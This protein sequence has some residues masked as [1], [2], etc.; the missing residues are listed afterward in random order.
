MLLFAIT[1][2]FNTMH[3]II[4]IQQARDIAKLPVSLGQISLF[5][6][7]AGSASAT[8]QQHIF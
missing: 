5:V 2:V 8:P 4:Y 1:I 3:L 7:C 6:L